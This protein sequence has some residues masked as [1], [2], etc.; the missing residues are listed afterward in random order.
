MTEKSIWTAPARLRQLQDGTAPPE[1]RFWPSA[2]SPSAGWTTASRA[3]FEASEQ[4]RR[5]ECAEFR[6]RWL[7]GEEISDIRRSIEQRKR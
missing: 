5:D 6:E 3:A 1:T 2:W 4:A 7:R